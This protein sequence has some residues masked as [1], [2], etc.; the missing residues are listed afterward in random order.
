RQA[1]ALRS[2]PHCAPRLRVGSAQIIRNACEGRS[3]TCGHVTISFR[4]PGHF[5]LSTSLGTGASVIENT[6]DT[7]APRPVYASNRG[8]PMGKVTAAAVTLSQSW[9]NRP[10]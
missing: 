7:R 3:Y 8:Q 9:P 4:A 1:F 2:L 10:R 5:M 6:E